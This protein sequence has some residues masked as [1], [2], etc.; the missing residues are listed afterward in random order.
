MQSNKNKQGEERLT[1]EHLAP[2]LPY[3]LKMKRE[4]FIGELLS[5]NKNGYLTISCSNWHEH[6]TDNRYKP[7]LRPV[8]DLDKQVNYGLQTY[9][10]TELFEMGDDG[11]YN[12]EFDHGNIKLIQQLKT[13]GKY[14]VYHDFNFMPYAVATELFQRHFDVFGLIGKGLAIDINTL[15]Q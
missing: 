9:A 12:Y 10:A 13:I 2:Y 11:G 6:I 5:I 8:T 4:N 3:G 14:K 1:I 15:N 7:I